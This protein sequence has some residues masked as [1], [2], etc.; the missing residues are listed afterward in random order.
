MLDKSTTTALA[1]MVKTAI[2]DVHAA[3][4][5]GRRYGRTTLGDYAVKVTIE[6]A[7]DATPR[8][9]SWDDLRDA[10]DEKRAS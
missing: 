1:H 2:R 10:Q 4:R 9:T 5:K 3:H 7:D 6:D 8:D